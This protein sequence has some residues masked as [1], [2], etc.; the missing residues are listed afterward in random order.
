M[1]Q[2]PPDILARLLTG[3]TGMMAPAA[4]PSVAPPAAAPPDPR[5]LMAALASL[6]ASPSPVQ[7]VPAQGQ[8]LAPPEGDLGENAHLGWGTAPPFDYHT[9]LGMSGPHHAAGPRPN[10]NVMPQPGLARAAGSRPQR[11]SNYRISGR[12]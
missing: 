9:A 5:L 3:R 8:A 6:Q 1:M 7:Q 10:P 12:Y 2:L 11:R 4:V